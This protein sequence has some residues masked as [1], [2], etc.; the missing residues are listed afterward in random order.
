[1]F[2]LRIRGLDVIGQVILVIGG[3]QGALNLN[4]LVFGLKKE[5]SQE[6][7]DVG[8]IRSTGDNSY[9]TFKD[10]GS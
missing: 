9:D 3:S 4:K 2:V 1:M 5:Y 6:L 10:A 8:F 7:K